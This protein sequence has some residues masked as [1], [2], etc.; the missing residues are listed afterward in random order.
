MFRFFKRT[1]FLL[2]LCLSLL[3]LDLK[4][5]KNRMENLGGLKFLKFPKVV[6]LNQDEVRK[7]VMQEMNFRELEVLLP[8]GIIKDRDS[9]VRRK[10]A[11]FSG[12]GIGFFSPSYPDRVFVAKGWPEFYQEFALVHELRHYLQWEHFP[13]LFSCLQQGFLGE[14]RTNAILAVMEGDAT[15]LTIRYFNGRGE[16]FLP[17]SLPGDFLLGTVYFVYKKGYEKV[18]EVWAKRGIQAELSLLKS[19]PQHTAFFFSK[20]YKDLPC[21]CRGKVFRLGMETYSFL[22]GKLA[23]H[24]Q[25]DCL[26]QEGKGLKGFLLF[27]SPDNSALAMKHISFKIKRRI[28]RKIIFQLEVKDDSRNSGKKGHDLEN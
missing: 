18:K 13:Q 27:D 5:V 8:L 1:V 4:R 2:V 24:L 19:P 9:Y 12:A 6:Y 15:W 26:C 25:G 17:P 21:K 20:D 3:P 10:K 16:G 14:D 28:S 7:L 22:L 11:L 23:L